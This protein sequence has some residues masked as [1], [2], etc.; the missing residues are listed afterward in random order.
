MNVM[1]VLL[2]CDVH[3]LQ[4][5]LEV[6]PSFHTLL[7]SWKK[8]TTHLRMHTHAHTHTL[9]YF[10]IFSKVQSR[11]YFHSSSGM[12]SVSMEIYFQPRTKKSQL[13]KYAIVCALTEKKNPIF[14]HSFYLFVLMSLSC[15]FGHR[16]LGRYDLSEL[17]WISDPA[18]F[19]RSAD[20]QA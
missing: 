13:L 16:M 14:Y 1:C 11:G 5:H 8:H 12:H 3:M 19:E 6:I 18:V 20:Y 9:I 4:G 7:F 10:H 15:L 17:I 2:H